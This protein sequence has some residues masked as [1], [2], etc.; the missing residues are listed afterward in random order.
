MFVFGLKEKYDR[1]MALAAPV[2]Y[3]ELKADLHRKRSRTFAIAFVL[4][5]LTAGW[6]FWGL[7]DWMQIPETVSAITVTA[8]PPLEKISSRVSTEYDRRK[9]ARY[10]S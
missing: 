1:K 4:A 8:R 9:V 7:L 3:W 5:G 10:Q 6:A 2:D